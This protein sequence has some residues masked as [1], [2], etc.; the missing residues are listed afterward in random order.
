MARTLY[1][2]NGQMEVVIGDRE[3]VLRNL[4]REHLGS[5]CVNLFDEILADYALT[6]NQLKDELMEREDDLK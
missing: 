2:N 4:L 3:D 6:V 1:L 5:D